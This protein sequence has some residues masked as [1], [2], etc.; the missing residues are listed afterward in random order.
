MLSTIKILKN[1]KMFKS[2]LYSKSKQTNQKNFLKK[3]F[4]EMKFNQI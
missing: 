2:I 3:F 4:L 1:E